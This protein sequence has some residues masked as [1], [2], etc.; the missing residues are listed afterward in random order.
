MYLPTQYHVKTYNAYPPC[1]LQD[2]L[3]GL[4]VHFTRP[5]CKRIEWSSQET[6]WELRVAYTHMMINTLHK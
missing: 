5:L 1:V 4:M 2:V 6:A 3:G